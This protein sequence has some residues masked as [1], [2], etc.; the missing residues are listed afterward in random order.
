[1]TNQQIKNQITVLKNLLARHEERLKNLSV[2]FYHVDNYSDGFELGYR[3][4]IASKTSAG[5]KLGK[6][7]AYKLEKKF[8]TSLEATWNFPEMIVRLEKQLA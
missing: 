3:N 1:M 2:Y 4:T 5:R 7:E 8:I 6:K